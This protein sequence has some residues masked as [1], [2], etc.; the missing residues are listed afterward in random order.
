MSFLFKNGIDGIVFKLSCL[1]ELELRKLRDSVI[2][3]DVDDK[4][5][6]LKN[7]VIISDTGVVGFC[8]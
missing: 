5:W 4:N 3:V 6:E 7:T 8:G 2:E 1:A